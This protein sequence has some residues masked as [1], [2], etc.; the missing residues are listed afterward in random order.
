MTDYVVGIEELSRIFQ[1]LGDA[2]MVSY[3]VNV[4]LACGN[5]VVREAISNIVGEGLIK[6]RDLSRSV[7]AALSAASETQARVDAVTNLVYAA[8][9][10][11]GGVIRPNKGKYLAIPVG[12]YQGSPTAHTDL[13]FR[14]KG[15]TLVM[16]DGAGN[17][18]YVLKTSV[19][20]P[21]RPYLRPA[22]DENGYAIEEEMAGAFRDQIEA[23]IK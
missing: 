2:L 9:H 16:V 17:V 13:S 21:A 14:G 11:F 15:D 1:G 5:A 7:H 23:V 20:I 12:T 6:A 18:Q 4:A 8:I 3:L 22:V 10:E 19:V